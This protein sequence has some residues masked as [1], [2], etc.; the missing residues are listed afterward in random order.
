ME[1]PCLLCGREL[2]PAGHPDAHDRPH[3]QP[4]GALIFRAYGQ[5]GSAAFDPMDGTFLEI[6]ICDPCATGQRD[7]IRHCRPNNPVYRYDNPLNTVDPGPWRPPTE[8]M[9]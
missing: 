3:N 5:Y 8:S 4:D 9:A 7:R 2:E 1:L 6:N